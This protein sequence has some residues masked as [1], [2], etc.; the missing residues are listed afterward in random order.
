LFAVTTGLNIEEAL[1]PFIADHDDYQSILLKAL[2][3]RLAEALTE[4]MHEKVRTEIWAN[5][6]AE[7]LDCAALINE[8]YRGIRPAPGYPACPDHSEKTKLFRLLDAEN[9]AGMQLTEGFAMLPA[10]AVCGYYFAHPESRYFVLGQVGRD[11]LKDYT[12]RKNCKQ[13]QAEHW[14]APNLHLN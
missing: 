11:Q 12:R 13:E 2:A 7:N 9:N 10:A 5:Q 4:R 1:K 8:Q 14:L 3:D 6:P